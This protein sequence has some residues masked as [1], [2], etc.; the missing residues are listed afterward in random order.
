MN[1]THIIDTY[2]K[3]EMMSK[4]KTP[5]LIDLPPKKE[6]HELFGSVEPG[7]RTKPTEKKEMADL[8]NQKKDY[9]FDINAVGIS[10]VKYPIIVNS[11][12]KPTTQTTIGT[13]QL[14]SHINRSAKGTNMSRF[15]E[16]ME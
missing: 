3:G 16:Q 2:V 14:A 9:L 13:F 4:M 12:V 1:V 6:R 5:L 15:L 8:Q 11:D 10:N 7:P